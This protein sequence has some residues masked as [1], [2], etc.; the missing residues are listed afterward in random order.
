[1][2]TSRWKCYVHGAESQDFGKI[3]LAEFQQ[4]LDQ[5]VLLLISEWITLQNRSGYYMIDGFL[6]RYDH[7]G[8]SRHD[9]PP[10]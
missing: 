1:M 9:V 6:I 2:R 8:N 3:Q 7:S 10:L 4:D 5:F